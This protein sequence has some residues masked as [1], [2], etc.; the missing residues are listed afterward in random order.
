M[1]DRGIVPGLVGAN[2]RRRWCREEERIE[3]DTG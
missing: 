2:K 1:V 3:G